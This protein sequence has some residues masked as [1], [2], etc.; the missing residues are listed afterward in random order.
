[1][2]CYFCASPNTRVV[3]S[4]DGEDGTAVRRRR[5]C[6]DCKKRFSTY[7][8][9]VVV[10]IRV[11]KRSGRLENYD[12]GKIRSAVATACRKRP[13]GEDVL[14]RLV[15]QV[16]Q[17]IRGLESTD[18]DSKRI[19]QLILERLKTLDQVASIRFA[20]VYLQFQSIEEFR[21]AVDEM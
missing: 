15:Q 19:G 21:E 16:D 11:I 14:E 12:L 20:S 13:I 4:R 17:D 1:M 10:P 8:R 2:R 3:D 5:V 18:V 6:E 7:E 9:V